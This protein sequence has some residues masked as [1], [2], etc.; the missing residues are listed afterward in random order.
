MVVAKSGI[1]HPT[2][3]GHDMWNI[4]SN[5]VQRAKDQLQLRRTEIDARY[6]EEQKAL[7]AE[8]AVI[9]T[10]ERA[11]SEF[12]V[13]L[14]RENGALASEPT[15]AV[16]PP[17]DGE[18][19]SGR[20]FVENALEPT[21]PIDLPSGGEVGSSPEAIAPQP[22]AEVDPAGAGEISSGLDILKPGSRWRLYRG[23]RPTDP[24]GIVSGASPTMD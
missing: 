4:T 5:N 8:I 18:E 24:E 10:L 12:M 20:E 17:G 21:A 2:L 7:D 23:N 1:S 16:D 13:R 11:A 6:A 9:E 22:A 14:S 3:R 19:I 15:A